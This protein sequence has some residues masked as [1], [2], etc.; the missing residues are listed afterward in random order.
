[1][2]GM[3]VLTNLSEHKLFKA[4]TDE[5]FAYMQESKNKNKR[6]AFRRRHHLVYDSAEEELQ[7]AS[8]RFVRGD[9]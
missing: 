4:E 7:Y 8:T 6:K 2:G 1:M 3:E 5:C 9:T